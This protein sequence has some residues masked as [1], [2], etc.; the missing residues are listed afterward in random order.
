MYLDEY[1]EKNGLRKDFLAQKIGV[2]RVNLSKI[3]HRKHVPS[4]EL[5]VKIEKFT[6]GAV[7]PKELLEAVEK[8]CQ[9]KKEAAE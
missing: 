4:L 6:K 9:E 2:S 3:I 7:T 8:R 1:I 5:A